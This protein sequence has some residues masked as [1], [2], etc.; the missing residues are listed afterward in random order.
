[1][2]RW[3]RGLVV[4]LACLAVLVAAAAGGFGW[5]YSNQLLNVSHEAGA[6]DVTVRSATATSVTLARGPDSAR[7]GTFG[8]VWHGGTAVVGAITARTPATI[9]RRLSGDVPPPGTL[10]RFDT[11]VWPTDPGE[12]RRLPFQDVSVPSQ[13]GR[14][15]AWLVPGRLRTWVVTVHGRGGTR[16][17]PLR[18]L[19][20]LHRLG[21]PVLDSTYRNDVG[22]PAAPDRLYHLGDTEWR[23][24]ESAVRYALGHGAR[25][26]VLYAWSMGGALVTAF[27]ARS[28]YAAK[29]VGLVLDAPVLDWRATLDLQGRNRRLP[30]ALTAVAA[31]VSSWRIGIRW[32]NFDLDEH[33]AALRVPTLL[34]H[35]TADDTVPIGPARRLAAASRRVTFVPVAGAGHTQEWNVNPPAYEQR[36]SSFLRPLAR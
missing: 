15:P 36:V 10:A 16:Q 23:D 19:P 25:R 27:L 4:L 3:L 9:T 13:L 5:Y 32:S 14:L 21:L 26:I 20:T 6:Y 11:S 1:M 18:I 8:L 29:V 31:Q 2:P 34:F 7:D 12:A 35:G 33:P 24:V 30:G 22:A 17:E 28:A